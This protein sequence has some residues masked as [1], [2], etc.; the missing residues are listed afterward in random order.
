[1]NDLYAINDLPR[2]GNRFYFK[3][4]FLKHIIQIKE[5]FHLSKEQKMYY[6]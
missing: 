4:Y 1:M 2:I 5:A 6:K 3:K